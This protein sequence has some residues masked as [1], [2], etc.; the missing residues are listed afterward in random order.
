MTVLV[1]LL[2][3]VGF[4]ALNISDTTAAR[5]KISSEGALL[6]TRIERLRTE[7][8]QITELR[9]AAT[10]E[11]ELQRAQSS[12]ASVWRATSR[13]RDVTLASSGEACADV[14]TQRQA[15]AA[16]QRREN[17]DADLLDAEEQ[18]RSL[19]TISVSDPQAEMAAQ[20]LNWTTSGEIKIATDDIRIGRVATMAL[21]PQVAGLVLMLAAATLHLK[22]RNS[23]DS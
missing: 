9:P 20:L 12:A 16:A 21:M 8:A 14:L 4:A 23:K 22:N 11:V 3:T 15:L 2:A 6:A 1:A 5:N 13:C 17:L 18:L 7:R 10:I 19:P